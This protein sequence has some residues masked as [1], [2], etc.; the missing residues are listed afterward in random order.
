MSWLTSLAQCTTIILR[1]IGVLV[2]KFYPPSL[3]FFAL[4]NGFASV[5]GNFVLI[6]VLIREVKIRFKNG[7]FQ[8]NE[9]D[10]NKDVYT[11]YIDDFNKAHTRRYLLL[12]ITRK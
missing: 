2:L 6:S 4:I 12:R 11:L 3:I 7:N 8:I 1:I 9:S 5:I 10:V